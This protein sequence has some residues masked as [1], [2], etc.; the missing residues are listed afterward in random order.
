ME[1]NYKDPQLNVEPLIAQMSI[2]LADF[3]SQLK[4]I[5]KKS[6]RD[7]VADFRLNKAKQ[8][9]EQTNDSIADISFEMGFAD[10][11]QF[12]RLFQSNM[13]MTPSQYRDKFKQVDTNDETTAYKIIE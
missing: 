10:A 4:R 7:Y 8:M 6:V 2:S 3:E 11:A 12:N 13:G 5:T 1:M 9:L